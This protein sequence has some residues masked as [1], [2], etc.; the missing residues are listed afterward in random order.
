[1]PLQHLHE[2]VDIQAAVSNDIHFALNYLL[3][4]F[5]KIHELLGWYHVNITASFCEFNLK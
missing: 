1:M 4:L 3:C 5:V 2:L